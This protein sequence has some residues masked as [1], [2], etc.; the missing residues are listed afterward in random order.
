MEDGDRCYVRR[1][2]CE[3]QF[4]NVCVVCKKG[5]VLEGKVCENRCS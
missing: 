1:E 4:G 2:G 5:L 3:I